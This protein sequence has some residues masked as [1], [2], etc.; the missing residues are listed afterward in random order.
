MI[1]VMFIYI[2]VGTIG[3][4][5]FGKMTGIATIT[6]A[7]PFSETLVR[8]MILMMVINVIFTY[9]IAIYPTN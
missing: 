4:L 9:P 3:Y 6:M 8:L 7:L 1:T 2:L 5:A